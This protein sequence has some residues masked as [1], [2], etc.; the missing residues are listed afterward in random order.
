M[1]LAEEK[2]RERER[3]REGP[4]EGQDAGFLRRA[5]NVRWRL[6]RL[7]GT[8][9]QVGQSKVW[10]IWGG[11]WVCTKEWGAAANGEARLVVPS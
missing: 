11:E 3:E 7:K 6:F 2:E 9:G 4:F 10:T 1:D 8:V 5:L